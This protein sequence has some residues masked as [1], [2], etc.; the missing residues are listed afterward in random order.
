MIAVSVIVPIHNSKKYIKECLDSIIQ[1]TLSDIEILC[2]DSST[3]GTTDILY[4]YQVT[5]LEI[6]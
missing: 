4:N 3:D 5:Y 6:Y 1:Q 2:I